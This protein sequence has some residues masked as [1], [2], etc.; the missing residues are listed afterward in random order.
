MGS[1][2]LDDLE[3]KVT[4]QDGATINASITA[5]G[6]KGEQGDTG[7]TGATGATGTSL[8]N[9]GTWS[10][11]TAYVNNASYTDLVYYNGS[12]YACKVSNTNQVP[13][14]TTY[15]D[16]IVSK[17]DTGVAGPPG[18]GFTETGYYPVDYNSFVVPT[19]TA[20]SIGSVIPISKV[21]GGLVQGGNFL[22][23]PKGYAYECVFDFDLSE[24]HSSGAFLIDIVRND[25][26]AIVSDYGN[27]KYSVNKSAVT[28]GTSGFAFI[29]LVSASSDMLV[30]FKVSGIVGSPGVNAGN[31][32]AFIKKLKKVTV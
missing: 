15:W 1:Y 24:V 3:I 13:T 16:L 30:H 27:K 8:R 17:G 25:T 10:S 28:N 5:V 20:L 18:A 29:D 4:I 23:L 21:R 12:Y 7:E 11:A 9:L 6:A 32:G 19:S 14:N 31:G 26:L 22:T 2:Y